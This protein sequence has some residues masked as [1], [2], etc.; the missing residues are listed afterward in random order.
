RRRSARRPPGGERR[1]RSGLSAGRS[2]VPRGSK[3]AGLLMKHAAATGPVGWCLWVLL[4]RWLRR[5]EVVGEG[6]EVSG[7]GCG[8]VGERR[9]GVAWGGGV[10]EGRPGEN[11]DG[12]VEGVVAQRPPVA[13]AGVEAGGLPGPVGQHVR[14]K[15]RYHPR[16]WSS[17]SGSPAR[18]AAVP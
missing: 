12:D 6:G 7:L 1:R 3:V 17:G 16:A 5:T 18:R 4:G 10:A 2:M 14:K 9:G 11:G 8:E 13:V 15:R